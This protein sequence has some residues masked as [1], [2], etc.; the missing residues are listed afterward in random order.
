MRLFDTAAKNFIDFVPETEVRIYVCGITPYDSAHLGHIFTFMTYD[1]LQRRLEDM[2]SR[3]EMVR[4]ITDVDEPIYRKAKA[5]GVDYRDLARKETQ[6]FQSIMERLN[7]R[8]PFAEPRASDYI[9]EMAAAVKKLLDAG[10]AYRVDDDIY[11]DTAKHPDYGG[12]SGFHGRLLHNLLADRGGDPDRPGKRSPLDFLLWRSVPDQTDPA[13]WETDIGTGRPGWH[14]ECSV[15]SHS[16]LGNRFDI[17]G[18][19]ADLIFPHHESEIAQSQ[20]L[21]GEP[22]ANCWVHVSPLLFAGEKMSKSLG[23]LVFAKDLLPTY[24]PD[25]IRLSLMHYH[26]H[27]GGEWQTDLLDTS[28]QLLQDF[29]ATARNVSVQ[30]AEAFLGGVRDALDDNINTPEVVSLLCRFIREPSSREPTQKNGFNFLNKALDLLGFS[31]IIPDS[32]QG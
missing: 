22:P 31:P 6:E 16:L 29:H 8:T 26:H 21:N 30:D 5:L 11:F 28:R 15:M 7:F 3:V 24:S 25:V 27:Y 1:L 12:F 10:F 18:G 23:N 32:R 14:I 4:N 17:H 9:D 2:G 13:R 19:G 20:A